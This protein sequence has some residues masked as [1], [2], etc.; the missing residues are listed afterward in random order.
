MVNIKNE[1]R[2]CLII[3]LI[4]AIVLGIVEGI[5]EWLPISST[6]H[7][8]IVEKLFYS[9]NTPPSFNSEFLLLFDVLVQL[10]AIFAVIIIYFKKLY[11][12]KY[13]ENDY[14]QKEKFSIWFK[15]GISCIPVVIIGFLFDDFITEKFYNLPT[16]A[17]T[18]VFYGIVF[19]F[20][21]NKI[22]NTRINSVKHIKK[23]EALV[24][25]GYQILSLIPGT[26]RSGITIIGGQLVGCSKTISAEYSFFLSVP[27]MLGASIYKLSKY[28]L[29]F[30]IETKEVIILLIGMLVA[31]LVSLAVIKKLLLFI[32][33]HGF[34]VFGIYRIILGIVILILWFL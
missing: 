31:M 7:I 23:R 12:F 34:K 10:G 9:S 4:Y 16:I 2:I 3:D 33:K 22:K 29:H 32:K 27:I 1:K 5:T 30:K 19:I 21:E 17:I 13:N 11:P 8:I 18:L 15:I 14:S 26:S 25:G 24:I 20:I 28:F 6:A